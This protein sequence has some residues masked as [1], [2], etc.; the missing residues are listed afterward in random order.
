MSHTSSL[1]SLHKFLDHE[2]SLSVLV[3]ADDPDDELRSVHRLTLHQDVADD[4]RETA[5][6]AVAGVDDDIVVRP[7]SPG[8]KPDAHELLSL[9]LHDTPLVSAAVRRI[10]DVDAAPLFEG[11]DDIVSRLRYYAIVVRRSAT[12]AALFFR[13]YSPKKELSR[14]APYALMLRKGAYS[15]V[16]S[17]VF[18]FDDRVDCFAWDG[19]LYISNAT[20]FQRIFRYF[21][22]LQAK[23][24]KTI[25]RVAKKIPIANLEEFEDACLGN[26]IMLSKLT[27]IAGKPYL[28][29]VSMRDIKKTIKRFQL[30]I[31]ITNEDG[32][33]KLVFDSGR[34]R[35]WLIL[36]LLDDDYLGSVMT[37]ERYE[38]NSK[39]PL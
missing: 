12:K 7:Y 15:R 6:A 17:K 34:E 1:N 4:F 25:K 8:Y 38:V 26:Q 13:S 32:R 35:R 31:P 27:A 14:H 20:Q 11:Q 28:S 18:L 36:K 10:G 39:V 16:R 37:Q 24:K 23:A 9:S 3:A 22:E 29:K 5:R 21:E 2:H 33:E 30:G 19:T